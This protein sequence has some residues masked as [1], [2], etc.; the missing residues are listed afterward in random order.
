[1]SKDRDP[2]D[3]QAGVGAQGG[4]GAID[5]APDLAADP[6][7][8]ADPGDAADPGGALPVGSPRGAEL[9]AAMLA[10]GRAAAKAGAFVGAKVAEGYRAIDPDVIRHLAH[11]PLLALASL[12]SRKEPVDPGEPDGHPPLLFVHGLGGNRGNFLP[13]ALYLKLHGRQ[14]SYRIHFD[15]G[16][17]IDDMATELARFVEAV[18]EATGEPQVDLVAHSLGGLVCRVALADHPLQGKVRTLITLGTPH[19]GTHPARYANTPQTR[20]LRPGSPLVRRLA[21]TPWPADVRGVTFWSRGDMFVLPAESAAVE[22]TEQIDVTPFSHYSYL[23]DP[24]SWV[25][26]AQSLAAG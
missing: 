23:I 5:P 14:R 20:D 7:G 9:A 3:T 12:G 16:R 10:V 26:V 15:S 2:N 8:A 17:S 1:M 25:A 4:V 11:T 13:M 18:V 21:E 24:K 22:G 19:G 6:G